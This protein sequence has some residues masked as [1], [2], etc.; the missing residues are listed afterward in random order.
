MSA[1]QYNI[2]NISV[3]VVPLFVNPKT[4]KLHV[5]LGKRQFEPSLGEPAL[6]GVLLDGPERLNEAAMRALGSKVNVTRE[7]ILGLFDLGTF[8]NPDRDPR[9]ATVSIARVALL[10]SEVADRIG[11]AET[12]S[13]SLDEVSGTNSTTAL[14]FD[15]NSIVHFAAEMVSEKLLHSKEFSRALLG[16]VFTTSVIRS[17]MTQLTNIIPDGDRQ[18]DFSNLG[19]VLK[20]SGWVKPESELSGYDT[21]TSYI[22]GSTLDTR[23]TSSK[24]SA[25]R[26]RPSREWAWL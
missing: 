9:G 16:E 15:H 18:I 1:E 11:E 8:D 2:P 23:S 26:G 7:D 25:G 3:D 22:T 20:N 4:K 17:I 5:L 6:P 12:V 13:Y 14:P 19:R 21:A 24:S 10:K